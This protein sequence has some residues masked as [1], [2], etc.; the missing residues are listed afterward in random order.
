M[1]KQMN[2]TLEAQ[3]SK[4]VDEHQKDWEH[5]IPLKSATHETIKCS[6]T[7]L[8]FGHELQLPV[9]LLLGRPEVVPLTTVRIC[10]SG[11][12]KYT[13]IQERI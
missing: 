9:D 13:T 2:W 8:Q 11:L 5:L 6:P 12:S 1:V 3:L 7:L 10:N 4:F